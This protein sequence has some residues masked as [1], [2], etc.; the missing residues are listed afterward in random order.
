MP[1]PSWKSVWAAIED[2]VDPWYESRRSKKGRVNTNVMC[3]GLILA[4]HMANGVPIL[5]STYRA[6]SQVKNIG[7]ARIHQILARHGE[8]RQFL[9]EGG[10]TS[11]GSLPLANA[12]AP[13]ISDA[14]GA[15]GYDKLSDDGQAR[16]RNAL[17][18]WFV[19]KVQADYFARQR[20]SAAIDP[21]LPVR[22]NVA[23]LLEAARTQGGNNAGA[24]AQHLVGAK[25]AMRFPD[26]TVSNHGYTTADAQ[27]SR[28]GDFSIGDT[29]IHV[30]MSPTEALFAKCG[31]NLADGYRPMVLV[32]ENR[33]DAGRQIAETTGLG[34]RTSVQAIEDYIGNNVEE[35]GGLIASGVRAELKKLLETYNERVEAVEPDPALLIAIPGNL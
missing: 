24:V 5:E 16:V 21:A 15:A 12:L 23:T 35:I 25:L 6:E 20:L 32:P 7:A 18:A 34:T 1:K 22:T 27:T 9:R 17:Q 13:I 33:L 14:A 3:V 10:R 4:D 30:T 19:G 11:R 26:E 8:T 31:Q 28:P 29:A 2:A